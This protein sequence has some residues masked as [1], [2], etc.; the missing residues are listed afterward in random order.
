MDYEWL[1]SSSSS[2]QQTVFFYSATHCFP[3]SLNVMRSSKEQGCACW[4][5]CN[6][7]AVVSSALP[8]WQFH[9]LYAVT[10]GSTSSISLASCAEYAFQSALRK[11]KRLLNGIGDATITGYARPHIGRCCVWRI[12]SMTYFPT[13]SQ[14]FQIQ[15]WSRGCSLSSI[16]HCWTTLIGSYSGSMWGCMNLPSVQPL[17]HCRMCWCIPM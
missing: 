3:T 6:M 1:S 13:C 12:D 14:C 9:H 5:H 10:F 17:F 15:R 16:L 7:C 11:M 8:M 4:E 2:C